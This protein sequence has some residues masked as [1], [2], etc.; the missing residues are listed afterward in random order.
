MLKRTGSLFLLTI[1]SLLTACSPVAVGVW[2]M[3]V[4]WDSGMET[5]VWAISAQPA[6]T[7]SRAGL[8]SITA[9]EVE[10]AGSRISWSSYLEAG[11]EDSR[12]NFNG[13]VDGNRL[14]GTLYSQAGNFQVNGRRRSD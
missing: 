2:D 5:A 7:F 10:L 12:I 14:F 3:E 4:E 6:L 11:D 8:D 9:Q 1:A 13:T